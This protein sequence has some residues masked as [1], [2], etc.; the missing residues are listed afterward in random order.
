VEDKGCWAGKAEMQ[1]R[2]RGR[3]RSH[4]HHLETL[5][6]RTWLKQFSVFGPIRPTVPSRSSFQ[7][8]RAQLKPDGTW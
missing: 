7:E 6:K 3:S 1:E 4:Q 8:G 2:D 5:S